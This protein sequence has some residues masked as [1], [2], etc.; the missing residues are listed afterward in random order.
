ML[1]VLLAIPFVP[2]QANVMSAT[3][4]IPA[5]SSL[6]CG[7]LHFWKWLSGFLY[8]SSV[9]IRSWYQWFNL[10]SGCGNRVAMVS[11]CTFVKVTRE[12]YQSFGTD[13]AMTVAGEWL[14]IKS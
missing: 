11:H 1:L 14:W 8:F 13:H 9:M 12:N 6:H 5:C 4:R 3:G 2:F 10:D 7:M